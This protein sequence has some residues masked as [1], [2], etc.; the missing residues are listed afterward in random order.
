MRSSLILKVYLEL[1]LQN[2]FQHLATHASSLE[3]DFSYKERKAQWHVAA[4]SR[5][6]I[7]TCM[8]GR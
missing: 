2:E 1:F 7:K 5:A 4:K 3:A 6:I 8:G